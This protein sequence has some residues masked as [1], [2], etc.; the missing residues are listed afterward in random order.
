[1]RLIPA[2]DL[3][4]GQCVRLLKGDFDA[5]TRYPCT[6]LELL[7]RYRELGAE[8]LH[9]VDLD[10]ARD[11]QAA[12]RQVIAELAR[13]PGIRLQVGGG[14]RS[15]A[16]VDELLGLGIARLAIGSAAVED[17]AAVE[18]WLAQLG[19]ERICLAFDV[20]LQADGVP[21]L[22]TRGWREATAL[23]LWDAIEHYLP[24]GLRHVLCTDIARDG[25]MSGPNLALYAEALARY[26]QLQWQASG[27]V[28]AGGDL[29]ALAATGVA[30]AVC[31][32]ALLEDRLPH[33]ALQPYLRGA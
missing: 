5:E 33:G 17:R 18:Q 3:R 29:Q 19:P 8:W 24:C 12:N 31:G 28:S 7:Q 16:S 25:A 26:P 32:K 15:R 14:V 2:I 20:A 4:G 10:G 13:Q 11:G 21:L 23:P 27:G 9:V 22:R 6:A 30:A 1:M